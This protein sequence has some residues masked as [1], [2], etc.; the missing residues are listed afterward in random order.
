MTDRASAGSVAA[1]PGK[2]WNNVDRS[3]KLESSFRRDLPIEVCLRSR[4][5]ARVVGEGGVA[6]H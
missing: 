2:S 3:S 1:F 6:E 5:G 4:G